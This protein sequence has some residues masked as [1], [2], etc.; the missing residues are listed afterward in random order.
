MW[1]SIGAALPAPTVKAKL[2]AEGSKA[3]TKAKQ[4]ETGAAASSTASASP[5]HPAVDIAH[6]SMG[7]KIII[8]VLIAAGIAAKAAGEGLRTPVEQSLD[9]QVR[10]PTR[11][12]F[13]RLHARATPLV[14]T[15]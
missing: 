13:A 1:L 5:A 15:H 12:I 2:Q 6:M 10:V 4:A 14:S 7:G 11:E 9:H 8:G 3:S